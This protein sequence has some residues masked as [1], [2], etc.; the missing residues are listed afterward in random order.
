MPRD[1]GRPKSLEDALR[2][3]GVAAWPKA[4]E[5]ARE[6]LIRLGPERARALPFWLLQ[7]DRSLK[8]DASR[9][10]RLADPPLRLP[11]PEGSRWRLAGRKAGSGPVGRSG[12]R[13]VAPVDVE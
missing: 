11:A 9:G 10:L 12:G 2:L 3:A 5:A 13:C 1:A 8:G 6:A 4:L 7:T